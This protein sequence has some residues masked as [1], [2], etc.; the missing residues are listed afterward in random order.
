MAFS[1]YELASRYRDGEIVIKDLSS[2]KKNLENSP[3]LLFFQ[4]KI[5]EYS[6]MIDQKDRVSSDL[7][8]R[9]FS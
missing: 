4:K 3:H 6:E 1:G 8:S 2:N 5:L 7:W 9:V